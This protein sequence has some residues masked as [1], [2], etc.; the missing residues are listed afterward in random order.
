[1]QRGQLAFGQEAPLLAVFT[2]RA[3]RPVAIAAAVIALLAGSIAAQELPRDEGGGS[4]SDGLRAEALGS[5]MDSVWSAEMVVGEPGQSRGHAYVGYSFFKRSGTLNPTA[6][7]YGGERVS[8]LALAYSATANKLGL[9]ASAELGDELV[10]RVGGV[11]LAV[12]DAAV[13]RSPY[14]SHVAYEWDTSELDWAVGDAVDLALAAPPPAIL[15]DS[16]LPARP[17]VV[18]ILADDLGWGDVASNNPDSAMTTPNIDSIATGG[19]NFTDAHSPSSVCSPTRYGLLTGR[20]AWRSWLKDEVVWG[21]N[22]PMI[23]QGQ[24]TLGTLL[25][26]QGYRTAAV[27]KW[28]LGMEFPLL[29]DPGEITA[30]NRGFDFN[31]PIVDGPLDHGFDEF[32]G[33][34]AN[35]PW[36]PRVYV[37]GDRFMADPDHVAP[38]SDGRVVY[39]EALDRFTGEAVSFIDRVGQ[40]ESPFFLYLPVPV[41]H[42]PVEPNRQFRGST[43]LGHYA[44]YV[45]QLDWSVGQVLDAIDQ[46]GAGDD[47]LVIVASDN[48]SYKTGGTLLPNHATH[49]SNGHWRDGKGSVY[50]GGHRVP[51]MMRWPAAIA[52]GSQVDA[53]VSLTD[54]YSTLA[55]ITGQALEAGTAPDSVSL[56]P[57]LRGEADTRGQPIVLHSQ[58]G[59][60][61][62]RDGSWKLVFSQGDGLLHT[63][64][65]PFSRPYQVYNLDRDPKETRNLILDQSDRIASMSSSL[66][67]IRSLERRT[68]SSDSTLEKLGVAGADIGPFDP[69]TLHYEATVDDKIGQLPIAA[70]PSAA[71]AS[72]RAWD[73][74][75]YTQ[76]GHS[77]VRLPNTVN[78]I[79]VRV[80]A[81]DN[82]STTT[83]TVAITK[84]RRPM[85]EPAIAGTAQEGQ[86]L[87]A[88]VSMLPNEYLIEGSYSYQWVRSNAGAETD[89]DG[90]TAKTY[91]AVEDDVGARLKVR[92]SY[93]YDDGTSDSRLSGPTEQVAPAPDE[94]T[95][96][97]AQDHRHRPRGRGADRRS[98]GRVGPRRFQA[99]KDSLPVV[100][101]RRGD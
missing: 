27:G 61:S 91:V 25:Q 56:V 38:G 21:Y 95:T 7:D 37:R 10:L 24:P 52:P 88:D 1:M 57:L 68:L 87:A 65:R 67:R 4:K 71:D 90:A 70:V 9:S 80:T 18:L 99:D 8:V 23:E 42:V 59:T 69:A 97:P 3:V 26:Q 94:P 81:P 58:D 74:Q 40:G 41:P 29:G 86:T 93:Y 55:E 100:G 85:G 73:G 83:Y 19:V 33:M 32:F 30:V 48:G 17:N 98:V 79:E 60:F 16:V 76:S 31:A 62:L 11:E 34:P 12:A 47:T 96:R 89:I 63:P 36:S 39:D 20:Y 28:H 15:D 35:S 101:R 92:V 72:I 13:R 44:D 51:L 75:Q 50:E 46:A 22:R 78:R 2:M 6:F 53:A 66:Q 82:A 45:A 14:V 5:D 49:H 64:H 77:F 84:E 43:G 54:L